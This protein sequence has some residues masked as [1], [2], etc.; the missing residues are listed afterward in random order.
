[1]IKN[2]SECKHFNGCEAPL[3]PLHEDLDSCV[4][5][6]DEGVCRS[7]KF[8]KLQW[9]R[10]QKRLRKYGAKVDNGYFTKKILEKMYAVSARTKGINPDSRKSIEMVGVG[11][12]TQTPPMP[13][14]HSCRYHVK[15]KC[16]RSSVDAG[17]ARVEQKQLVLV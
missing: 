3:C 2:I 13:K 8:A 14:P 12:S 16:G 6:P 10:I 9:I 4:F 7:T 15:R 11:N 1:M 5:Y 17:I